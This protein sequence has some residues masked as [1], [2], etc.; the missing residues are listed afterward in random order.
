ME[1]G[2]DWKIAA[3]TYNIYVHFF[4]GDIMNDKIFF[5]NMAIKEAIKAYKKKEVPVG[6]I[7]VKNNEI[8]AKSY[9]SK[10]KSKKAINHAEIKA[11]AKACKKNNDWRLNECEIYTTLFPCPMCAG[12]IQE[13]RIAKVYYISS[14]NNKNNYYIS[15]KIL[16]SY[17]CKIERINLKCNILDNF[18]FEIRKRN[19][20]RETLK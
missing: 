19:V 16:S 5:M 9:N 7:I 18:F 20:S 14:T 6:C 1:S 15:K 11:I 10:E 3:L 13:A 8:I 4:V 12:A 2:Q 17:C